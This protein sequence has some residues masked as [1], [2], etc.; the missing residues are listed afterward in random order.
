[1]KKT[2][3]LLLITVLFATTACGAKEEKTE[4]SS[5]VEIIKEEETPL[6][7]A[8]N[9]NN[10]QNLEDE[11]S[12]EELDAE[13]PIFQCSTDIKN[14]DFSDGIIQI[15]DMI[16]PVDGTKTVGEMVEI[17]ENS[18]MDLEYDIPLEG[19]ILDSVDGEKYEV[20]NYKQSST[21]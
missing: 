17:L 1:M 15:G 5:S 19:M 4:V 12:T 6:N 14:A 2:A 13:E 7:E 8:S 20:T 3:L 10:D 18:K 21:F 11:E 9:E 16:I